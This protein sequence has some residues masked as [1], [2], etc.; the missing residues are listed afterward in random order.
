MLNYKTNNNLG[1]HT[2]IR[3][4]NRKSSHGNCYSLYSKQTE[5]TDLVVKA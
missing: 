3:D 5:V 1:L 2:I 4:L